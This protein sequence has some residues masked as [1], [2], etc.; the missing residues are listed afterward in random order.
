MNQIKPFL[1]KKNGKL[2]SRVMKNNDVSIH[3]HKSLGA[4]MVDQDETHYIFA[5]KI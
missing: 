4:Y 3:W 2:F 5:F 1:E